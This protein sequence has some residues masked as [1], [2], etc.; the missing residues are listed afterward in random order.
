MKKEIIFEAEAL[1]KK[2]F[3]YLSAIEYGKAFLYSRM[4][5]KS[6]GA[7]DVFTES[8]ITSLNPTH[9]FSESEIL[10]IIKELKSEA[11]KIERVLSIGSRW[12][13]DEFMLVYVFLMSYRFLFD[14]FQYYGLPFDVTVSEIEDSLKRIQKESHNRK[15]ALIAKN[16]IL[17]N[18]KD[19]SRD[20]LEE[21]L[22]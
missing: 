17:K 5:K 1:K 12:N 8:D 2:G 4:K 20:W 21:I 15:E 11:I 16:T 6:L 7:N 3:F 22:I 19:L 10:E 13:D 18:S 14:Y 9:I